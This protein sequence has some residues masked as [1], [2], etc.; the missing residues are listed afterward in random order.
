MEF[1]FQNY[2]SYQQPLSEAFI[3]RH[4]DKVSWFYVSRYQVLSETFIEKYSD[5]VKWDWISRFQNIT[6][7]S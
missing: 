1:D 2:E 5:K 4:T 6:K 7:I 3:Q